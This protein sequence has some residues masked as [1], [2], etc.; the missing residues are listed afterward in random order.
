MHV[1]ISSIIDL[2][3]TTYSRLHYFIEHLIKSGHNVTVV[4][5][6]DN[7]KHKDKRQRYELMDKINTIYITDK[8]YGAIRQKLS[9]PLKISQIIP[10]KILKST[11]VHLCYNSLVLGY[12]VARRLRKYNVNTVY[13]LADDLP[14]MIAT[15]PQIPPVARKIASIIGKQLLEKNLKLSS[16]VMITAKE[17]RKS[18]N[19]SRFKHYIVPNGVNVNKFKPSQSTTKKFIVGYLGALREWV[20]LRPMLLAVKELKIDI[21]VLVVGGEE[22]LTK[23]RKFVA[24]NNMQNYVEFTGNVPYYDVPKYVNKMDIAT[25]PFKKTPVTDGT[26]PLKLLEYMAMKKPCIC[27]R[28]NEIKSMVGNKVLYATKKSEWKKNILMLYKNSKLR[29]KLGRESRKFVE[30]NYDW[31]EIGKNMEKILVKYSKNKD[32]SRA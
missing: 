20:D 31:A 14:E 24:E 9:F 26:C 11:D 29:N 27:S 6:K 2:E 10:E 13:D 19:I 16:A 4:S 3:K 1:L 28:L 15:S 8:Q 17:F 22:D 7:W 21:K 12:F 25:I 32:F 18:M 30:K 5:I 23:Y